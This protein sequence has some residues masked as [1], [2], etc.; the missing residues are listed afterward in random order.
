MGGPYSRIAV[1]GL[2]AGV[3]FFLLQRFGLHQS[4]ET[5]LLW[6]AFFA[7]AAAWLAWSQS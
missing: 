6:A 3:L 1:H 4:M 7:A 2:V 5:S